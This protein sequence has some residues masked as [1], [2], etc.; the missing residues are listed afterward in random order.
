MTKSVFYQIDIADIAGHIIEIS[1]HF[2]PTEKQHSLT[3]PAWIPGS[4]MIRDFARNI[5]SISAGDSEGALQLQQTDK[6]SWQL[7]CRQHRVTVRYRVYAYDLSVRAAYVDDEI[8][9]LNPACLCLAVSGLQQHLHKLELIKPSSGNYQHWRL[10]T[11]LTPAADTAW[12][13]FGGYSA[14]NYAEL[15]DAPVLAGV[16]SLSEFSIDA[17]PHYL[18]ISGDNQTDQA[19]FTADLS[20]I[21]QTQKQLFGGLPTDLTRYWFLLWISEDGYG[22]LEHKDATLLL[23][24]RKALPLP[25]HSAGTVTEINEHYQDLLAL[26]SHEYFHTWWVKRLKPQCFA[27]YQLNTEQYTPQLWLYEGFT[28]YYDDLALVRSGLISQQRYITT[29][30]KLISRVTRNPSNDKQSLT[31]SSFNAWTKFYKQDENAPN[32]VVSYYAKGALLALCLHSEL[33]AAGSSLDNV[34]AQLWQSYLPGGTPDNA[35]QLTLQNMGFAELAAQCDNWLHNAQALPLPSALSKLGLHLSFRPMQHSDDLGGE[36][37]TE[38]AFIGIQS[39]WH[40]GLLQ[41]TQVYHGSSAHQ[42][43]IM[44][45]DQ[46][47]ALD[48]RKITAST[49]PELLQRHPLNST[50]QLS[51]FRK[52]RLLQTSITLA[53]ATQQVAV[54]TVT[55]PG[56]C[57]QWLVASD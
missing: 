5:T 43:G 37:T 56:L 44:V 34:V 39:K 18:V 11:S 28:S 2:T 40:N 55:D 4:Y 10:A 57:Q 9:I 12:L 16:F 32:A 52:D 25:A 23:S 33:A 38:V 31:D 20:R 47:L 24:N 45:A 7:S 8:A 27:S 42:A 50:V 36:V 29:L 53:V 3:L 6:Q 46:L 30:E 26:C 41:V 13:D 48:G 17:I 22:G 15:I 1:L 19:R 21:C 54:L 49:W 35:L 14:K 51:L